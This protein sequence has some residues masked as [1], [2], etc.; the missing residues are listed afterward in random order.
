MVRPLMLGGIVGGLIAFIWS[1]LSWMVF[2]WHTASLSKFNDQN[3]VAAAIVA[4]APA[5][6]VY[7]LPYPDQSL[8]D[9]TMEQQMK[10]P[11]FFGAVNL[12]GSTEMGGQMA[13]GLI[14]Q[15]IAAMLTTWLVLKTRGLSYGGRVMFVVVVGVIAGLLTEIPLWNWWG[16]STGYMAAAMLDLVIAS[17]LSGLAIARFAAPREG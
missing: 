13:V 6:G 15:I 16:F 12:Q 2:P 9:A 5:P 8:D 3:A 1:A 14:V 10:G 7:A 4:N 11:R 17:L